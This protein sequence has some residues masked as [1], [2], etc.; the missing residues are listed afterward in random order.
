[1]AFFNEKLDIYVDGQL[2]AKPKTNWS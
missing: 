2:E 1:M